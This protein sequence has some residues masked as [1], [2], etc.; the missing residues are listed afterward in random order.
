M[1]KTTS[2]PWRIVSTRNEEPDPGA[3]YDHEPLGLPSGFR[4][5]QVFDKGCTIKVR[6]MGK[7]ALGK[8]SRTSDPGELNLAYRCDFNSG[9]HF[10]P[11]ADVTYIA[12]PK[13]AQ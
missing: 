8:V 12:P 3:R 6:G 4:A 7:H 13:A 1:P 5:E 11:I 9:E 10:V 2:A